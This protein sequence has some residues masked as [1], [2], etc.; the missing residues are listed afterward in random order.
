V[1]IGRSGEG[2]LWQWCEFNASV[3]TREGRRWDKALPEDEAVAESS[4]WLNE[5]EA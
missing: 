1:G 3:S 5:K 4:S 2:S